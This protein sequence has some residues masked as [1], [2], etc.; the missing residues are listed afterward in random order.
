M[1][2]D[3]EV[4]KKIFV[5]TL[6]SKIEIQDLIV[7]R[8]TK[9]LIS[10]KVDNNSLNIENSILKMRNREL[11]NVQSENVIHDHFVESDILDD[12]KEK[13]K[14]ELDYVYDIYTIVEL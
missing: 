6:R 13:E 4:R 9:E 5:Q 14:E 2:D 3:N 12:M 1:N 7:N 11:G 10:E 8:L